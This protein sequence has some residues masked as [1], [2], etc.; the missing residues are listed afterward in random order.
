MIYISCAADT[1]VRDLEALADIYR[2]SYISLFDM[3]PGTA[4]FETLTV[5]EH[6]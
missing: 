4:H 2:V 6:R 3:F 1:L 5:L